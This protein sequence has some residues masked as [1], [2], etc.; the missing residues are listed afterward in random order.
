[1]QNF[2]QH[3]NNND[4][5]E[6]C[7]SKLNPILLKSSADEQNICTSFECQRI[8]RSKETLTPYLFKTKVQFHRHLIKEKKRAAELLKQKIEKQLKQEQDENELIGTTVKSKHILYAQNPTAYPILK[9]PT[10]P[11]SVINLSH[12][13]ITKYT[14]HLYQVISEAFTLTNFTPS[15][16]ADS[17]VRHDK[18]INVLSRHP[19]LN[20]LN[21]HYCTTCKG[22]CCVKGAEKAY[23]SVDT[24]L[25]IIKQQ[26]TIRPQA[27]LDVYL[28]SLE[29]KVIKGSCINHTKKGC[30]LKRE[31]RSEICNRFYCD[32]LHEYA[33]KYNTASGRIKGALVINRNQNLWDSKMPGVNNVVSVSIVESSLI[34]TIS[35]E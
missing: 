2:F 3:K 1:M 22:G 11:S 31:Y 33:E 12:K 25:R 15:V 32:E 23:L 35:I 7:E 21:D 18:M 20:V 30:G 17:F 27:L 13:R 8:Y 6:I 10:G 26:P 5:C 28:S 16:G 4:E 34:E 14:H 9:L 29:T 24:I 19:K